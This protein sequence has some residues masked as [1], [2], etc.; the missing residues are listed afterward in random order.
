MRI[1]W[2]WERMEN[3]YMKNVVLLGTDIFIAGNCTIK[4]VMLNLSISCEL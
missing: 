4:K 1:G 2:E 3:K